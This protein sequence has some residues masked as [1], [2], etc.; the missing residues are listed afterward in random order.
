MENALKIKS[1]EKLVAWQEA[2]KLTLL[3]YKATSKF[4]QEEK[5]SLTSQLRRA[6]VSVESC[7]AEGY[8][9]FHY[10]D[11]LNF[12]YDSR[13]SLGELM[14]QMIDALD[15]T[16]TTKEN[17]TEVSQQIERVG[18]ILGGLIRNTEV[19]TSRNS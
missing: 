13:G 1:F 4:P 18:A 3:V 7:I 16:F 10:K 17:F 8:C 2:H 9:R 5:F 11:K 14:S 15:L 6:A 19:R 12:Y